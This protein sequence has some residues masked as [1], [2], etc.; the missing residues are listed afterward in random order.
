MRGD[1]NCDQ[2]S[3]QK[4]VAREAVRQELWDE[5]LQSPTLALDE[6]SRRVVWDD[7]DSSTAEGSRT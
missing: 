2:T 3:E 7:A 6:P 1:A 4:I 5:H